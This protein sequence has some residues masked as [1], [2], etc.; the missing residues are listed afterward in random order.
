MCKE[1]LLLMCDARCRPTY[2]LQRGQFIYEK[3]N[4]G[5]AKFYY[6]T[7]GKVWG[8]QCVQTAGGPLPGLRPIPDWE[9][10]VLSPILSGQ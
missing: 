8:Q 5:L 4:I 6:V 10:S 9:A 2:Q 3:Y 7:T 1:K